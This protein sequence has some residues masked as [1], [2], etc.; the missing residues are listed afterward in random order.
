MKYLATLSIGRDY[1]TY[2]HFRSYYV[3]SRRVNLERLSYMSSNIRLNRICE[4]CNGSFV[5]RTT[6]TRFC[7]DDCAKRSYKARKRL[8][9]IEKSNQQTQKSVVDTMDKILMKPFLTKQEASSIL[10]VSVRT[11]DRLSKKGQVYYHHVGRRVIINRDQ[12]L[13]S[14]SA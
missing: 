2:S 7:G 9:S 6:V 4:F 11:L 14:F 12:L 3:G 1:V 5:A 10:G 8:A 13:N